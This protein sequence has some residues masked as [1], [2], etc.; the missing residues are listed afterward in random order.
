MKAVYFDESGQTGANL[1]DRDQPFFTIGSTDIE[2]GE[3]AD[4]IATCFPRHAGD[5]LKSKRLFKQPRSRPGLIEFARE[6]GKRP[7]SFCG[8]QIDKRFAIVGKMVDNIVEP[9]LHSRGYD[10]YTDGYARRFANTMMAVFA[11]IEDQTSVDML[12]QT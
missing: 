9:L 10:F 1:F 4:I 5:E 3:A 8:S 6:I 11:D 12:L 7:N 2:A